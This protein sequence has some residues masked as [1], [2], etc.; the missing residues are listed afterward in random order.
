MKQVFKLWTNGNRG[1]F[2]QTLEQAKE[3]AQRVFEKTGFVLLITCEQ[4]KALKL[5]KKR[6]TKSLKD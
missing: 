3:Q 2:F 4:G 1:V 5:A 6:A